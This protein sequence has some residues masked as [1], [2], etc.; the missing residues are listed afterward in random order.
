MTDV[1]NKGQRSEVMRKVKSTGNA[2]TELK[3]IQLF[4]ALDIKGWRRKYKLFGNPDFTFPKLK[5]AVFAD[6][7]FWHGHDCR[8]TRPSQNKEYWTKKRE[9]NITRDNIVNQHLSTHNW[10]VIRLW[11]CEIK[12]GTAVRKLTPL[13]EIKRYTQNDA[14]GF[15]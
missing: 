3:L 12:N 4:K 6:G 5:V 10:V 11:E 13:T 7:C 8:N 15:Q 14:Y 2:S 1:F 9:R